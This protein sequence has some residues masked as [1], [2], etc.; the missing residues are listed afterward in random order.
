LIR[1]RLV[2]A[3]TEPRRPLRAVAVGW[4]A[5]SIPGLLIAMI[6]ARL[7]P[8]VA[9][10]DIAIPGIGALLL[11]VVFSP[12][13]E[14]LI[15]ALVLEGFLLFLPPLVAIILSAIGWGIAHSLA[16][17][18]WGLIIWWPFLI[19]S[20]LYVTW[21]G[22]GRVKALAIVA[23]VHGLNNLVPALLLLRSA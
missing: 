11:F 3:L 12:L 13:V 19:F 10:P 16:A 23:A 18:A 6:V 17:L 22:E 7:L 20:T 14:T 5:A 15:M 4:L 1:S 9:R 8:T 21:R 2:S